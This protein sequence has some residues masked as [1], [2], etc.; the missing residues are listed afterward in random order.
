MLITAAVMNDPDLPSGSGSKPKLIVLDNDS[1]ACL[2]FL[3]RMM[4]GI[5]GAL[6]F[7]DLPGASTAAGFN[8]RP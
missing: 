8:R 7:H 4:T 3:Q 5:T 6:N 2:E 1:S